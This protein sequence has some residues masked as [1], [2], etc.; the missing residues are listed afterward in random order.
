VVRS[1]STDSIST[2]GRKRVA[3]ASGAV[4]AVSSSTMI[5]KT[6]RTLPAPKGRI[7]VPILLSLMGVPF[8]LVLLIWFFFFR[9]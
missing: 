1:S 6:V 9:G 8:G 7:G 3:D 2:S 4:R 5:E